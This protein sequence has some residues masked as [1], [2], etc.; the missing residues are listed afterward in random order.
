MLALLLG[1]C[2]EPPPPEEHK[3]ADIWHPVV[4]LNTGAVPGGTE[5]IQL[6]VHPQLVG[7]C[8]PIP[9]L[10]AT[11][12]GKA[13]T[14]LHGR[15]EGATPYDRD[16][17]VFEFTL[18][19]KELTFGPTSELTVTDGTTTYRVAIAE[20]FTPRV[21]TASPTDVKVGDTVTLAWAPA[22][23][24]VAP[25]GKV[26]LELRAGEKRVLVNRTAL[27]FAPGSLSFVVPAGVE[28]DVTVSLFGTATIQ[29]TVTACEG[30]TT[31]GVSRE[32]DVPPVTIHVKPA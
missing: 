26:G 1:A 14:Q 23:D 32:Y 31:C 10:S 11:L 7:M 28:G 21:M 3:L 18:D 8:H 13:M 2:E 6:F 25:K 20:L 27:T 9:T 19:P 16:C 17:S 4:Q 30:P 29:P 5:V 15:V 12:D 24:T 22:S